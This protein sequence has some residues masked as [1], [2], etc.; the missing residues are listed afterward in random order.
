MS[1]EIKTET[2]T[3]TPIAQNAESVQSPPEPIEEVNWR[4]FRQ[5]REQERKDKQEAVE[6]ARK[7]QEENI[8]LQK[9]LEAIVNKPN[10]LP[11]SDEYESEESKIEK[12]VNEAIAKREQQYERERTEREHSE[13]PRRLQNEFRDFNQICTEENLD[14]LEYHYPE[15]AK[16]YKHMPEC[17]EKWEGI[18]KSLKR[19]IPNKESGKESKKAEANLNKPA[20][21]SRPGMTQSGDQAPHI[22]DDA[23]RAANWARMQ[24]TIKGIS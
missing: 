24:K 22:M 2:I 18:Y 3:E 17:F 13:M 12:K 4:K 7:K 19:F 23:K 15:V 11:E 1:E 5:E 20:A 14:Y 8:A 16:P 9:A 21:L 10:P 6:I